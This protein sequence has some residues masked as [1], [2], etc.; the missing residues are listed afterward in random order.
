MKKFLKLLASN[1]LKSSR[2]LSPHILIKYFIE[3][4]IEEYCL[5][6][7]DRFFNLRYLSKSSLID[8]C[9][10]KFSNKKFSKDCPSFFAIRSQISFV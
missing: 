6:L 10:G 4:V 2:G 5:D 3:L 1:L 8:L 9:L 7:V